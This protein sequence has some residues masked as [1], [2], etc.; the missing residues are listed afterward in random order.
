MAKKIEFGL[1]IEVPT[2]TYQSGKRVTCRGGKPLFYEDKELASIRK[3]FILMLRKHKPKTKLV[4][5][6]R[7]TVKWGFPMTKKSYHGQPKTTKPDTDNLQKLLKDCMTEAGFWEDDAQV[8]SEHIEKYYSEVQGI[9]I[10]VE[11]V[12]EIA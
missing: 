10:C 3:A 1:D 4:G 6:L 7:L 5:A 11:E 8:Y 2:K 9:R 12:E